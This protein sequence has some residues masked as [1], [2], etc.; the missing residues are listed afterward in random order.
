MNNKAIDVTG[1]VK[2]LRDRMFTMPSICTERGRLVTKSYRETEGE[3][4]V[5]RQAKALVKQLQ[6]MGIRIDEGELIVGNATSKQRGGAILPEINAQFLMEEMDRIS[7]REW[8]RFTPIND[9]EKARIQE[10]LHYWKG[11]SVF[12]MW[13]ARMP[14][15]MQKYMF[16]GIMGGTVFCANGHYAGHT[17]IDYG[18]VLT[19]GINA[20]K[21]E[22]DERLA[23]LNLASPEDFQRLQFLRASS[24]VLDAAPKFAARY[25]DLADQLAAKEPDGGR[26]MELLMI[27]ETCRRVPGEPARN[28]YEALQS[29][30]FVWIALMLEGWGYGMSFGRPDQYLYPFYKQDVTSGR[31]TDDDVRAL[32]SL[33]YIKVNGTV[34]VTDSM[35]ALVF[36]GFPQTVNIILGGITRDGKDAVN[37]LSYLFLEADK[38]VGMSQNDLVVRV[39]RATPEAFIIKAVEVAKA[40]KGKLKFMSDE[41]AIQQLLHDGHPIESARDYIITGCNSPSIPGL[42]FD[43]PGGMF[44][45]AF[46]LELALNNGVSRLSGERIGPATGD[47]RKFTCYDNIFDAFKKQVET[48]IPIAVAYRNSD[49]LLYAEMVPTPFQS[50]LFNGPIEKGLDITNG[51]TLPYARLAIS[52]TGAPNVGDSLAAIKKVV[53][54]DRKITM[55]QLIDALDADFEEHDEAFHLLSRAP[56]FGNDD[57][58]VDSIVNDVLMYGCR[59]VTGYQGACGTKFNVAAAA[60]TAN[61]ALGF[62][63]GALPDGRKAGQPLSEGGISPYQGRNVS[64]PTATLR[65][66]AKLDHVHLTN[67]S[68]LNMRFSPEA[69]KDEAGVRRFVSIL[70]TY[71]E[72]GGFFVQFNIVDA[73]TLRAAQRE[74][75][76]YKDLLVRVATYS[77]YFVELSP[78]LQEDVIRRME[79]REL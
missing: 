76:K 50:A 26:K 69:L 10:S 6:E 20:I 39:H 2:S 22:V 43:V 5:I 4:G 42:S 46:M 55:A 57:D 66:V 33:L 53:F 18:K 41:T 44:N 23:K 67:G 61:V 65:S 54:E 74:P 8:D 37:E 7:S 35:A 52:L 70:R 58:Y 63:V 47:P 79:F 15:D 34:T 14:E 19:K 12:D 72:T 51:G 29:I 48:L 75:D 45:L 28:F 62:P 21:K 31:L 24:F 78:E 38:D 60:V 27:A 3:P 36:G 1:R 68:V 73:E 56:K 71:L 25:A 40:L 77:A 17:A 59:V 13:R 16:N 9:E 30:C 49:R 32:I 11:K 64:G